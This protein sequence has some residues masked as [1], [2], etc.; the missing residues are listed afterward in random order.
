MQWSSKQVRAYKRIQSGF[1][2]A[3]SKRETVR[4]ITLTSAVGVRSL[5]KDFG[6]LAKRIRRKY[7]TFEYIRVSTNEGNGVIH[8][9][10]RGSYI[11]QVW[12][13]RTWNDI[14]HS[15]VVD[16]RQVKMHRG[17]SSYVVSQ[18]VSNQKSS[19][20]RCASSWNWI[21]YGWSKT[22]KIIHRGIKDPLV[23]R[24]AWHSHL[25]GFKVMVS[26]MGVQRYLSPFPIHN[27]T[28]SEQTFIK[29]GLLISTPSLFYERLMARCA[30]LDER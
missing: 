8:V 28:M 9:L 25:H 24:D 21:Y 13:S 5:S 2:V 27:T 10:Y 3:S 16:I 15:P 18:Y 6:V 22:W 4:F 26:E 20:Q 19:Y 23:R 7:G 12:L 17:L 1:S 29:Q 11:P 14:H 30:W